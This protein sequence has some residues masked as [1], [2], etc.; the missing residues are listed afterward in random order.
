MDLEG[1]KFPIGRFDRDAVSDLAERKL[2]DLETIVS[3]PAQLSTVVNVLT[4]EQLNTQYRPDGWTIRQVVHHCADSH[5]NALIR[6]KLALTED[7]PNIKPYEEDKW[8][9]L[10]DSKGLDIEASLKILEGVHYRWSI[11]IDKMTIN[12]FQRSFRHPEHGTIISL[13]VSFAE[14]AWHCKHH[15]AHITELI[16][17]KGWN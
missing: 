17:R 4:Q 6:F 9:Y 1:L 16:K 10:S 2:M 12:D 13:S 5:M 14:Y 15:L 8:A 7:L 3:F 11:L